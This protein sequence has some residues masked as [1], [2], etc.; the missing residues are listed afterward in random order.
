[1]WILR[2]IMT[3]AGNLDVV[4]SKELV[5]Y[6]KI[7][8]VE[9][10]E[11]EIIYNLNK[12]EGVLGYIKDGE[13]FCLFTTTLLGY[14]LYECLQYYGTLYKEDEDYTEIPL[15]DTPKLLYDKY[16]YEKGAYVSTLEQLLVN[17]WFIEDYEDGFVVDCG[18]Y[19]TYYIV[20]D[21][22]RFDLLLTKA[23]VLLKEN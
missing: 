12:L 19:Y 8:N 2:E 16:V 7:Q 22:K 21:R 10:K 3:I 4:F 13:D 9:T 15:E 5:K 18:E 17:S 14:Q 6:V 11:K 1:M 20:K 23:K